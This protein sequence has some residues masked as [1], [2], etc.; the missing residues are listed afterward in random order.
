MC[1]A[2]PLSTSHAPGCEAAPTCHSWQKKVP[3]FFFT[4]PVIGFQASICAVVYMPG[5]DLPS[6]EWLAATRRSQHPMIGK[7]SRSRNAQPWPVDE[8]T[9]PSLMIRPP[10]DARC[11][12]V[13]QRVSLFARLRSASESVSPH[14]IS[15]RRRRWDTVQRPTPRER[16]VDLLSS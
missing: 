10:E 12:S 5:V 4:V 8:T 1:V 15:H 11:E 2:I 9:V 16:R 7:T 14:T 3:F 13:H 6:N